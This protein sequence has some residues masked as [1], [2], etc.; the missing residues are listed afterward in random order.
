MTHGSCY[1]QLS[2]CSDKNTYLSQAENENN[3]EIITKGVLPEIPVNEVVGT[4]VEVKEIK[5]NARYECTVKG[6]TK[7]KTG[8]YRDLESCEQ[9]CK[10]SIK[11]KKKKKYAC[12]DGNCVTHI[13]GAYNT[14]EDCTNVCTATQTTQNN[15]TTVTIMYSCLECVCFEDPDGNFSTIDTCIAACETQEDEPREDGDER[16]EF[17]SNYA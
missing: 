5:D 14:L 2:K 16:D 7:N 13:N 17:A 9:D 3:Q 11:K 1:L 6:C 10:K 15:T 12:I 8:K 4:E